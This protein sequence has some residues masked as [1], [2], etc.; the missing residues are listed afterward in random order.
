MEELKDKDSD[1][2]LLN[3]GLHTT[4]TGQSTHQDSVQKILTAAHFLSSVMPAV[5]FFSYNF[6]VC[7]VFDFSVLFGLPI[8]WFWKWFEFK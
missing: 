4:S 5:L 7:G 1:Q 8:Y 3:N 2:W 6:F